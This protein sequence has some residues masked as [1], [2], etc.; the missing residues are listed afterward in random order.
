MSQT[1][2]IR[3]KYVHATAWDYSPGGPELE[4]RRK[5]LAA[6]YD[7]RHGIRLPLDPDLMMTRLRRM[8]RTTLTRLAGQ[9]FVANP[10]IL[11]TALFPFPDRICPAD[12]ILL[13]AFI[14]AFGKGEG[15]ES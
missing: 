5:R 9:G 15:D 1:D 12:L 13:D 7:A 4:E 14:D 11:Y 6:E 8:T 10:D 2:P 3:D